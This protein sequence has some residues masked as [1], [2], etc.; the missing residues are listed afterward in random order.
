M[1][2]FPYPIAK[3]RRKRTAQVV[4]YFDDAYGTRIGRQMGGEWEMAR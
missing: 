2:Y 4:E 3:G 1:V